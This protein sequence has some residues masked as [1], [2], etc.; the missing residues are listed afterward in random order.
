MTLVSVVYL[1]FLAFICA[2]Y[3]SI[4]QRAKLYPLLVASLAFYAINQG[5]YVG[6][7]IFTIGVNYL[8]CLAWSSHRRSFW[9]YASVIFN[10][11]LLSA[12]KY[13]PAIWGHSSPAGNSG[14]LHFAIPIGLSFFSFQAIGY[15]LDLHWSG[16]QVIAPFA[17]YA[18]FMSF[19]PQLLAG[20]IARGK[21]FL[22]QIANPKSFDYH[23][24]VTGLRRIVWG[25]FKKVVIA[26]NLSPYTDVVFQNYREHQGLTI[27]L[28][29][30]AYTIQIYMDFSAYSDIAIGS[31][32]LLGYQLMENFRIP[33]FASSVTD[34]WRRWHIS[35]SS[36]V[37]DYLFMPLQYR[38]RAWGQRG[39]VFAT[40]LTFLVI[41]LWHGANWTFVVFG[42]MQGIAISW[43][44]LTIRWREKFWKIMP[45]P[46]SDIVAN[47]LVFAFITLSAIFLRSSSIGEALGFIS[48]LTVHSGTLY[49]GSKQLLIFAL[50]GFALVFGVDVIKGQQPISEFIEKQPTILR[51]SLYIFCI[52][53]ILLIGSFSS[54]NFIYYQF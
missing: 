30:I 43:E 13:I 39:L 3:Y 51:W 34:F 47:L 53:A 28:A 27:I 45:L 41:G 52:M 15:I 16:K 1:G 24:V 29:A 38:S 14:F 6:I 46:L 35:L 25:L 8:L 31:A 36:W 10:L 33:L 12:F 40:L 18:L 2:I 54:E 26:A 48:R 22:P 32:R 21:L 11:C 7:L 37:R 17:D 20:P 42:L 49:I 23:N 50:T 5:W 19:F 9:V 44:S 4:P